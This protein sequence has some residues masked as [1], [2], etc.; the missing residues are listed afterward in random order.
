MSLDQKDLE[1][2]ERTIYKNGDDICI[3]IARSFE[4][5][6]ER[7]SKVADQTLTLL[8][9]IEDELKAVRALIEDNSEALIVEAK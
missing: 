7:I 8:E 1:Q 4:R 6:E 5:L 3:S 9:D 2:I